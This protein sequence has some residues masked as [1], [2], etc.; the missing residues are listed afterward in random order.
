MATEVVFPAASVA[1]SSME[2]HPPLRRRNV[3]IEPQGMSL[4]PSGHTPIKQP[5]PAHLQTLAQKRAEGTLIVTGAG[6]VNIRKGVD[7]F[8]AVAADVKRLG[9]A[10]PI[11]FLWV[12]G[13]YRPDDDMSYSVYLKEQMARS[14]VEAEIT[15]MDEVSDLEQIYAMSD[16]FMLA[17]RLDPLPNVSIDAVWRGIPTICFKE[18]SGMADLLLAEPETAAGVVPYMDVRA[19]AEIIVRLASDEPARARLAKATRRFAE[20]AFNM[21]RYVERLDRLGSAHS[22][23]DLRHQPVQR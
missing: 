11:H 3:H 22:P 17:S 19:A 13:G 6:S 21:E 12:G 16:L 1:R 10:R 14:E 4:L 15:F 2:V 18:A 20:S 9:A 23:S 7:S 8:I 5:L